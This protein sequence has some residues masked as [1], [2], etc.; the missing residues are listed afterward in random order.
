M[1]NLSLNKAKNAKL[2]LRTAAQE[3]ADPELKKLLLEQI[4]EAFGPKWEISAD[5]VANLEKG[6]A[7]AK[8]NPGKV[9][10]ETAR[11]AT[12]EEVEAAKR[13]LTSGGAS[14]KPEPPAKTPRIKGTPSTFSAVNGKP[15]GGEFAYVRV[16]K[17]LPDGNVQIIKNTI[18][19]ADEA[20]LQ[21]ELKKY[22]K[23]IGVKVEAS[24]EKGQPKNVLVR[25]IP[26]PTVRAD[27]SVIE[28]AV[29]TEQIA[30]RYES[31]Y[32]LQGRE[33]RKAN[34]NA[35]Y[36]PLQTQQEAETYA[37]RDKAKKAARKEAGT[38]GRGRRTSPKG[39]GDETLSVEAGEQKRLKQMA[40]DRAESTLK[41]L[42][43]QGGASVPEK[44][45]V[46]I[47]QRL[48]LSEE[49]IAALPEGEKE[50]IN[51]MKKQLAAGNV[52][53]AYNT[54]TAVSTGS[55]ERVAAGG[56]TRA[57]L[58]PEGTPAVVGEGWQDPDPLKQRIAQIRGKGD[59]RIRA[60]REA[61]VQYMFEEGLFNSA[62]G[63][64]LRA[65]I[66]NHPEAWE[67]LRTNPNAMEF[68]ERVGKNRGLMTGKVMADQFDTLVNQVNYAIGKEMSLVGA[69]ATPLTDLAVGPGKRIFDTSGKLKK[70][71]T[72]VDKQVSAAAAKQETFGRARSSDRL[73]L[74][75]NR[76]DTLEKLQKRV[77]DYKEKLQKLVDSKAPSTE[78]ATTKRL[79]NQAEKDLALLQGVAGKNKA[80]AA[81]ELQTGNTTRPAALT[82]RTLDDQIAT[83]QAEIETIKKGYHPQWRYGKKRGE[84]AG[85]PVELG[86]KKQAEELAKYEKKLADL[87]AR[88]MSAAMTEA[89][90]EGVRTVSTPPGEAPPQRQLGPW[91][92][93]PMGRIPGPEPKVGPMLGPEIPKGGISAG[94]KTA[95]AAATAA[96]LP[97]PF[98]KAGKWKPNPARDAKMLAARAK[99]M[100]KAGG[101]ASK[102]ASALRFLGPLVALWGGYE[103]LKLLHEG[104]VGAADEERLKTLEALNQISGGMGEDIQNKQAMLGMQRMVDMA[105][106][107][108]QQQMD[109]RRQQFVDDEALN[110][111]LAGH[112]ANLSVLAQPSRPSI[113]E[114]M[115]RM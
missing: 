93:E 87:Q 109:S 2:R 83:A 110:A 67:K 46:S 58:L 94:E 95:V 43:A 85:K 68:L 19:G 35:E 34:P 113:A 62:K 60:E 71:L 24:G 52:E 80:T 106:I 81:T 14:P 63:D 103:T 98:K 84:R 29:S 55:V 74:L 86:G 90:P 28:S 97:N 56:K 78:R 37:A 91:P 9:V 39:T 12:P 11:P 61:R 47:L 51:R 31:E 65:W 30:N 111:L 53:A 82:G 26:D 112:Q 89:S 59:V 49:E 8:S 88:K 13:N 115:A 48:A 5:E 105:A 69:D 21:A 108:R 104:T 25:K 101:L 22:L 73:S 42:E 79:L 102:G 32:S 1:A 44:Y 38:A 41:A 114:M 70:S 57:N 33:A 76:G 100:G 36:L 40:Q 45:R 23:Q 6:V 77:A 17:V 16:S 107:Q 4:E 3:I 64:D 7:D 66:D 54:G 99:A 10:A 75:Q 20:G 96:G 18:R 15:L 27:G 72:R 92:E 50:A